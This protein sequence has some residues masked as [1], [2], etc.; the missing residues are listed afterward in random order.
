MSKEFDL[1]VYIGRFQPVHIVHTQILE[2]ASQLAHKVLT[3][4]SSADKPRTYKDPWSASERYALL[5][6]AIAPFKGNA[7]FLFATNID[8]IY[9]NASWAARVQKIVGDCNL[10]PSAKIGIIGAKKDKAS[11][12]V[13]E[14]FPQWEMVEVPISSALNATDIRDLYFRNDLNFHYLDGVLSEATINFLRQFALSPSYRDI[15]AEKE[16]LIEHKKQYAGLRYP[17]IFVAVDAVLIQSGHILLIK[18]RAVP[19]KGLWAL[20]GGY[21]NAETDYSVRDAMIRELRE[22]TKLKVPEPVLIGNIR[23]VSVFDHPNRSPRGRI[24]THAHKIVLPAGPLPKV[25]GMDDAEKAAW[26][27]LADLHSEN[28]FEDHYEIIQVMTGI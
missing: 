11:A 9:N 6:S 7:E 25:K 15:I 23:D 14:M 27:P 4:V 5:K 18:R 22:E 19:G 26:V 3:I 8:T 1:I 24:I 12:E 21:M 2:K 16:F 20:P 13:L 10:G 28:M 17:P